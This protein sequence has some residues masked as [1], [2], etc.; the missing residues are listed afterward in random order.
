MDGASQIDRLRLI[1]RLS[2]TQSEQVQASRRAQQESDWVTGAYTAQGA[3]KAQQL[4][5]VF[6]QESF[7]TRRLARAA[8]GSIA[9]AGRRHSQ[10]AIDLLDWHSQLRHAVG[11]SAATTEQ[12]QLL[13]VHEL[14]DVAQRDRSEHEAAD[15]TLSNRLTIAS[16]H[17]KARRGR[18]RWRNSREESTWGEATRRAAGSKGEEGRRWL[19][20][21]VSDTNAAF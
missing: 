9:R 13:L 17:P 1:R 19:A 11:G 12:R 16:R 20:G 3:L 4:E 21:E 18:H 15:D 6:V 2:P 5:D 8:P 14:R 7:N 10:I